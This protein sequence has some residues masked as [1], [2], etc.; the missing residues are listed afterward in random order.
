MPAP[1]QMSA[2]RRF[3]ETDGA[4][5]YRA[6]FSIPP[7][8]LIRGIRLYNRVQWTAASAASLTAGTTVDGTDV[9]STQNLKTA[10][11]ITDVATTDLDTIQPTPTVG[12]TIHVKVVT[13]GST[14]D[15]GRSEVVVEYE[16][17]P[18]A[19]IEAVKE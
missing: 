17:V 18:D 13:T 8:H 5:T 10:V 19:A 14:G 7:N 11:A 9:Y 1:N 16:R 2:V 4:G 12:V 3:T 15:A 6:S